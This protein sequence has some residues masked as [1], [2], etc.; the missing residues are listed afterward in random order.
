MAFWN[1]KKKTSRKRI[2]PNVSK[3]AFEDSY[4]QTRGH[5]FSTDVDQ[6]LSGWDTQAHSIDYYLRDELTKLRARSRRLSRIS[7]GARYLQLLRN[8]V[9]GS[10]GFALQVKVTKGNSGNSDEPANTAIERGYKDWCN[11]YCDVEGRRT[12]LDLQHSITDRCATDG[13]IIFELH[14]GKSAGN[15]YGFAVREIDPELLD[16]TRNEQTI[17]GGE[18]RLGVEYNT[19]GKR[20]RY[21]FREQDFNGSYN[22]GK[23]YSIDAKNI[24]HEFIVTSP[25]QSRGIPWMTPGLEKAKH[26]E[27]FVEAA[28]I[29]ARATASRVAAL[30]TKVGDEYHGDEQGDE[31]GVE[32]DLSRPG[33]V[34]DI[35]QKEIQQLD[36]DYPT[37]M[38]EPFVKQHIRDL[39]SA[40]NVTYQSLSS[41]LS[42]TSFG[43]ARTGVMEEREGYMTIQ[44]W[45]MQKVL[46]RIY[47]EWFRIAYI[48]G[49]ITLHNSAVPLSRPIT[50]YQHYSFQGKRWAW[51][52]PQKDATASNM[53]IDNLTKSRSQSI[54]DRGGDPETVWGE[55][56]REN[57]ILK[58][59][60]LA[61][62]VRNGADKPD[63]PVEDE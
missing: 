1:R 15:K 7:F 18:I 4:D 35:G 47:D 3:L 48:H 60:D 43:S 51:I 13:E 16:V 61:P 45:M 41:D 52:D 59:L 12:M 38:Y 30:S 9:S 63:E 24:L 26:L 8:N 17:G 6:F 23:T 28:L 27:K 36:G 53:S 44:E 62:V 34:W 29:R 19:S 22:S 46:T 49:A 37:T 56:A 54:R 50:Y 40:W 32:Y 33:E 39:A 21:H 55:I 5:F 11:N 14:R 42:D 2:S 10:K 31:E 57:A 58:E 25:N 20:V